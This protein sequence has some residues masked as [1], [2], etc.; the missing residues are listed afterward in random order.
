MAT[1]QAY[2]AA[3][4][5]LFGACEQKKQAQAVAVTPPR[6]IDARVLTSLPVSTHAAIASAPRDQWPCAFDVTEHQGINETGHCV[7]SYGKRTAC[8][9]PAELLAQGVWGCPDSFVRT[10]SDG[11]V[12][13]RS[14]TYDKQDRLISYSGFMNYTFEWDGDRLVSTTSENVDGPHT[15]T[16]VDDNDRVLGLEKGELT[17]ELTFEQGRLVQLDEYLYGRIADTAH[18]QWSGDKPSTINVEVK[19]PIVGTVQR[20]FAYACP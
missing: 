3:A 8:R 15:V 19:G 20:T 9:M 12:R 17:E 5:I 18:L 11:M 10:D 16:Y 7:F 6:L 13:D 4:L 14:F 1:R 2:A